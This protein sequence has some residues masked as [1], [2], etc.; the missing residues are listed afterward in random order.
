MLLYYKL[1]IEFHRV[2]GFFGTGK[3]FGLVTLLNI[4]QDTSLPN[5][6]LNFHIQIEMFLLPI[7]TFVYFLQTDTLGHGNIIMTTPN[8]GPFGLRGQKPPFSGLK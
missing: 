2:K 4:C 3:G 7:E 5:Q 1:Y 6:N 8:S